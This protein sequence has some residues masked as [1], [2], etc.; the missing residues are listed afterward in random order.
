M[1]GKVGTQLEKGPVYVNRHSEGQSGNGGTIWGGVELGE[2]LTAAICGRMA[3]WIC[4]SR[5]SPT[6]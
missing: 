6:P 2:V 5:N 1:E 4:R 3:E